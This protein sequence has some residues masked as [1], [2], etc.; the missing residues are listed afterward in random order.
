MFGLLADGEQGTDAGHTTPMGISRSKA[1]DFLYKVRGE[2]VRAAST[3]AET[4]PLQLL[5]NESFGL[6]EGSPGRRRQFIDWGV[7]HVEHAYRDLWRRFQGCLAHRTALIRRV[8]MTGSELESWDKELV[9][10]SNQVTEHRLR[11]LDQVLPLIEA[12]LAEFPVV[13]AT[14]LS[15][16]FRQG[17]ERG[18]GFEDVLAAD[19][20]RDQLVG[21]THH[22]PHRADLA[23][24]CG[25]A[26]AGEV[27]SRG[28]IKIVIVA[29]ILAQG[30]LF[31][32]LTGKCCVYLLDD[33]G[34]ELDFENLC[35]VA[36]LL[37]ELDA[38]VFV[39]GTESPSAINPWSCVNGSKMRKMRVFH[40][41]QG[42]VTS[43]DGVWSLEEAS[44]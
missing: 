1:G 28:Q 26:G 31:R 15:F 38:Q 40:V 19:R 2:R 42:K 10:L 30:Y 13:P 22:G 6:L 20:E 29:M 24:R 14:K 37:Q 17:W 34:A 3:L 33:L 12:V 23:I 9:G 7:F 21:T 35:H 43:P 41:E 11:Y 4:L 27:L 39:T 44:Q 36:R 18:K 8:K 32:R 5:N 25:T 16:A